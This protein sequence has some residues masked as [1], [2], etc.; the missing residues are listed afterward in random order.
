[1]PP[2]VEDASLEAFSR[3]FEQFAHECRHHA[4]PLYECLARGVAADAE[5]LALAACAATRPVPNLFFASVHSLL[6]DGVRHPVAKW[7]PD[8]SPTVP[9][10]AE[11]YPFFRQFCLE[12]RESI[13]HL[14][15]T[16]RVQTNEVRRCACL[17]PAFGIAA[18]LAP[19]RPLALIEVG[20]SAGLNLL[21]DRYGYLYGESRR[22][23]V[24]GSPVQ[25]RCQLRG[26]RLPRLPEP[27]P[28]IASRAG[29]DLNP[30]DGRDPEATRWLQA[31]VWPEHSE[32]A[33]LLRQA[34]ELLRR[35]PPALIA[36]DALELL[37]GI[38]V[39]VPPEA[40]L[41][42]YHTYTLNQ[43]SPD[44][45]GRFAALVEAH[46]SV[47]DLFLISIE[48]QCGDHALLDLTA[49]RYGKKYALPLARCSA[50]GDW[51]EWLA[52]API[53]WEDAHVR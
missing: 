4:S 50:H 2:D 40:T 44:Q 21:W 12:N 48:G 28:A 14:L 1:M 17:L 15:S 29:V 45:R 37:P 27:L 51:L 47:R 41:C 9:P 13:Q 20:T 5:I 31:L 53:P 3:R 8:L 33:E 22:V 26:D 30:I 36:G 46:A 34:L 24:P 39:A 25:I 49:Y 38:L 23:G 32:R 42:L 7:Y 43:F 11:A 52:P 10:L 19:G 35:E 16:R 18:A 6:L